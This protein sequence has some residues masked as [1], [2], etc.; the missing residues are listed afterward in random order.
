[1]SYAIPKGL[2][3]KARSA[4][5]AI[6]REVRS[7]R[8][9]DATSG[10]DTPFYTPERWK[11]RGEDYGQGSIL[12]VTHDGGDHAGCFNLDYCEYERHEAMRQALERAGCWVEQCTCWYSAV[13]AY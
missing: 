7:Q 8:G 6:V 4:A 10:G 5:Q 3:R 2:T 1:M 9:A 13:Y 12:I 11:E